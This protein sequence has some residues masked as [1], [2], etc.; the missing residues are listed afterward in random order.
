VVQSEQQANQSL[1]HAYEL[2]TGLRLSQEAQGLLEWDLDGRVG[3]DENKLRLKFNKMPHPTEKDEAQFTALF[4]H[5]ISTFWDAQIGLRLDTQPDSLIYAVIG[6][7]GLAP[8]FLET[9]IHLFISEE[10]DLSFAMKYEK[11]F[12][13]TQ[14]LI[15]KPYVEAIFF[16]QTDLERNIGS[17]LSNAELGIQVRYEFN[18]AMALYTDL[19]YDRTFGKTRVFAN[20]NGDDPNSFTATL[21]LRFLF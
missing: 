3:T 11:D 10:G 5:T 16:A 15:A 17:G 20:S 14:K 9:E 2:E 4:S 21:G 18:R 6:F 1:Y 13:L 19:K 8:Y 12:L 7:E